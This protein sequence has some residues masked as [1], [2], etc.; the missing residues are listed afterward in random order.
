ML[1]GEGFLCGWVGTG[2]AVVVACVGGFVWL[3]FGVFFVVL[4]LGLYG[5]FVLLCSGP[6]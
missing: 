6:C 5:D 4:L 1:V 2:F 3:L